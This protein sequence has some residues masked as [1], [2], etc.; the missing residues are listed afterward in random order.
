MPQNTHG[1]GGHSTKK[2]LLSANSLYLGNFVAADIRKTA[3]EWK[4]WNVRLFYHVVSVAEVYSTSSKCDWWK[5]RD[6]L[7]SQCQVTVV[8]TVQL[9]A[10]RPARWYKPV[11]CRAHLLCVV[12]ALKS[13]KPY[14]ILFWIYRSADK[15]LARP[16]RKQD[17]E[18]EGS[19]FHI[20]HL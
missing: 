3:R 20:S 18:T 1:N 14:I 9:I 11:C 4:Q 15:T 10:Q 6:F 19:E 17:T 16:G 2:T 5:R 7:Q 12:P 8:A 13:A